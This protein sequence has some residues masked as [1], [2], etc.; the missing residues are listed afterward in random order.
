LTPSQA[1]W[2]AFADDLKRIGEKITGVTGARNA[3][4]RAEGYRYL[5]RLLSAAH[6]LEME[7]DRR[8]PTL[9][10]MMTPIRKFK[11][12]GTD[13]LYHEA[14]LDERLSYR[15]EITRGDDIFFSATVYAYDER[16]AYY[17]VDDLVDEK[18]VW[19]ERDGRPFA[20][21]HLSAERPEGV[22]NWIELRGARP[23]LFIRQYFPE[24]AHTTDEGRYR[25]ALLH[26]TCLDDV[27][28]PDHY[29]EDDLV[30]GLRR[31]VDF[32]EDATDVSI[33]L[34]IF[35]GLNLIEYDESQSGKQV[36]VTHITDGKMV[37]DD[38]R[39]D[40]Y[41][42]EQLAAMID[43]KL[44]ANNLPGPGIQYLGAWFRLADDE[45]IRIEGKDVPCRY[46]SCQ[47]LTR[48]LESGDYRYHRVGL[49]NR[50]VKLA[51]DGSF[52]I[53]ACHENPGVDNWVCTQGYE[54]AHILI[55]TL[56]ADPPMEASFT[57]V[58]IDQID[59]GAS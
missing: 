54:N 15:F 43:P 7:A 48:Y 57:V 36:D 13:T 38:P 22:E 53:Y 50:Q 44:V 47:I 29:T 31:V 34:S 23:I 3:R 10:R 12:D 26:V 11:G 39:H 14:K 1:A 37:L 16:D 25:T 59:T 24:F 52:V 9:A 20:E 21:I 51:A 55:R 33:G 58:K 6:Q 56:L 8:H 41:T 2:N 46:W 28:I 49:N 35:A 45:A 18:I 42:P 32:V 27:G 19:S 30:A 17:I 40:A 4:E 5:V